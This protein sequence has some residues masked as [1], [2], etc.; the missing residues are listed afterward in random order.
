M[1]ALKQIT[2]C[3]KRTAY[4]VQEAPICADPFKCSREFIIFQTGGELGQ[5]IHI[6]E[7]ERTVIDIASTERN[8][9]VSEF[10]LHNVFP[11]YVNKLCLKH[12]CFLPDSA[13]ITPLMF[14]ANAYVSRGKNKD[15]SDHEGFTVPDSAVQCGCEYE[16]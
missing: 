7:Y 11:S 6:Q 3:E 8:Y 14:V 1:I 5:P 13:F 4:L 15:N 16:R 10:F 12:N 9:K 2:S